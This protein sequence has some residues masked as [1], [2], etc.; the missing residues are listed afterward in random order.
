MPTNIIEI[1]EVAP[2]LFNFF[3]E[4]TD[5]TIKYTEK[6]KIEKK[7]LELSANYVP[8][9]IIETDS[10]T[11]TK[12]EEKLSKSD[13]TIGLILGAR[14][15]GKTAIAVKLIENIYTKTKKRCYALGF[16]EEDMPAW[17]NIV[18]DIK[19]IRNNS[20]VLIDEG[21]ILFSSRRF[22]SNP[23]KLLSE[24]ILIAR[25]KNIS[26]LFISQ[27]SA[28]LEINAIRQADYLI[29]KT[30]SLL[31]KDFERKK[32]KEIYEQIGER[33]KTYSSLKGITYIYSDEFSGFVENQLPSF[34][35]KEISKSFR[36]EEEQS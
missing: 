28:N 13:S 32:I 10:G 23:N 26:I 21:G 6:R 14:G 29:L 31:Q 7:R 17:I 4:T 3:S 34:W 18:S 8:F 16:N 1:I 30:S 2:A 24:L 15:S 5:K 19:E 12:F 20:Y 35:T 11:F 27:N 33:F 22:M 9:K 25:H 36:K